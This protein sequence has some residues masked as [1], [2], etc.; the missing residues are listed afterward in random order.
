MSSDLAK[1]KDELVRL[2]KELES[3]HFQGLFESRAYDQKLRKLKK[4][5]KQIAALD[6]ASAKASSGA[7]PAVKEASSAKP[8]AA[9][10]PAATRPSAKKKPAAKPAAKA[11]A[12][13]K[14]A[15]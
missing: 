3:K 8:A 12:K 9:K 5:R 6:P 4:L 14:R 11:P 10:K 2:E 1:L 13:K 15:Q 7:T